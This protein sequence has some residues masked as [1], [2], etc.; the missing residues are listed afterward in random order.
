MPKS[1]YRTIALISH[2]R[3]V[4]LKILQT[5]FQ[6]YMSRELPDFKA[7]LREGRVTRNQ[8]ANICWIT[9]KAIQVKKNFYSVLWTVP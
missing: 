7:G 3:K 2:A 8:I 4:M 1:V 6:E 5:R 9:E